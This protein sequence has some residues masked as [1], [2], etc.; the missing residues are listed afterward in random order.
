M[1]SINTTIIIRLLTRDDL[2]PFQKAEALL[3]TGD[4]F[5]VD[6]VILKTEQVLRFASY[7]EPK[8]I[9]SALKKLFGL[10]NVYW[11]YKSTIATPPSSCSVQPPDLSCP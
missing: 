6:T 10:S 7:F 4:S 11:Q 5:I 9:R 3:T 8:A 2:Q 1:I